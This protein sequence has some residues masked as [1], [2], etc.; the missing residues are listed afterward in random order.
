[1]TPTATDTIKVTILD[2]PGSCREG[3]TMGTHSR[4][5][6]RRVRP[7]CDMQDIPGVG[8]YHLPGDGVWHHGD[9]EAVAELVWVHPLA[10]IP[11]KG[12]TIDV[13]FSEL[14]IRQ[15]AEGRGEWPRIEAVPLPTFILHTPVR[16]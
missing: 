12:T 5:D 6:M 16:R 14:V 2:H 9:Y 7:G 15:F 11:G 3:T 13:P 1:M 8:L 10:Y 4:H